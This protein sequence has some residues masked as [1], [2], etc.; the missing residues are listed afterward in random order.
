M[1]RALNA[2]FV[3]ALLLIG[4]LILARRYG[5][6]L[7]LIF[8]LQLNS[9]NE[10]EN[11]NLETVVPVITHDEL[12]IIGQHTNKMIQGLKEKRKIKETFGKYIGTTLANSILKSENGR[13]RE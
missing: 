8:S 2:V 4:A 9:L 10:V 3:F 7:K 1:R 5:R 12:G 6:N 11:G 13:A